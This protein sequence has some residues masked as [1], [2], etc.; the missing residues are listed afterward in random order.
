MNEPFTAR[1]W[2]ERT[3]PCKGCQD[4]CIGCHGQ[5]ENGLFKCTRYAEFKAQN[6]K[7]REAR[8]EY[9]QQNDVLSDLHRK[10]LRRR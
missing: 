1:R 3:A 4:R 5:D 10:R 2:G 9:L 6:D 8:R 7:E